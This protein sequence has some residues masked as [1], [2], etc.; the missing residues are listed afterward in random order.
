MITLSHKVVTKN[1]YKGDL[2]IYDSA[3][4]FMKKNCA[5]SIDKRYRKYDPETACQPLHD[6]NSD[7]IGIDDLLVRKIIGI[8]KKGTDTASCKCQYKRIAVRSHHISSH[9]QPS[10]KK[11]LSG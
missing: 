3:L 9:T 5:D 11:F 7:I 6:G 8:I 1:Q 4:S 2:L 10:L